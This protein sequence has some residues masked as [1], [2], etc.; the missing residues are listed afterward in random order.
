MGRIL[1]PG[2]RTAAAPQ[3]TCVGCRE[4]ADRSSLLRVVVAD[5][6]GAAQAVVLEPDPRARRPGRGSWVHPTQDCLERAVRRRAFVRALRLR[7]PVD[8]TAVRE[9]LTTTGTGTCA[10]PTPTT[11]STSSE[12]GSGQM[13][14][15]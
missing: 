6:G 10:G 5:A 14:T 4:R 15:R 1:D 2:S 12:S 8:A 7:G 9:H 11:P 13:G 3:R